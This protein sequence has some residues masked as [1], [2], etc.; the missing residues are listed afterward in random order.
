MFYADGGRLQVGHIGWDKEADFRMPVSVWKEMIEYHF[1]GSSW[2]RL[3]RESFEAL[4][5]FKARRT[6]LTWEQTI[7]TL[8]REAGEERDG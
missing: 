3:Q 4:H 7:E 2:L 8:L 1:P 6:L 5:A